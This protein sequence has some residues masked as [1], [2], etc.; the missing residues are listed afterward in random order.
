[1]IIFGTAAEDVG[2]NGCL[3]RKDLTSGLERL[4]VGGHGFMDGK[5]ASRIFLDALEPWNP[6]M[7]P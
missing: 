2:N 6:E 1:M 7:Q 5:P 4:G 3:Q